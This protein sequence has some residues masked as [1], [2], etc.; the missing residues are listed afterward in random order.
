MAAATLTGERVV[1]VVI[2]TYNNRDGLLE[3]L[4]HLDFRTL[5][6]CIVVDDVSS[7]G[8]ADAV[9]DAFPNVQVVEIPEH[10]GV[11]HA[12]NLGVRSGA[13]PYVLLLNDDVLPSEGG[14]RQ[15]VAA[16]RQHPEASCAAGR[17]VDARTGETQDAY[18]PRSF[19]TVR[20]LAAR[21][22]GFERLR[23]GNRW[24]G[25]HLRAA[26]PESGIVTTLQQAAGAC[27]LF[28]R[29]QFDAIGGWDEDF[30]FY[31]EDTDFAR[32]LSRFGP[33]VWVGDAT[34]RHLGMRSIGLWRR[35]QK[36][37]RVH[38]GTLA[39]AQRHFSHLRASLVALMIIGVS[40]PRLLWVAIR[41]RPGAATYR[42]LIGEALSVIKGERIRLRIPAGEVRR[43]RADDQLAIASR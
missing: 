3:C 29:D 2:P 5:A 17:L 8:T 13:A 32:R 39:Y 19:P 18:R 27:F 41:R 26:L 4:A 30:W 6:E 22:S 37:A 10:R 28:R 1:D 14:V 12:I 38:F 35:D 36:H 42:W 25:Q 9:R 34:F 40:I 21:L 33:L 24:S 31:Y 16:L 20:T 23:P 15:L 11:S 7:D 43:R